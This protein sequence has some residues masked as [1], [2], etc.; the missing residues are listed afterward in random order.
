MLL[1]IFL[2][3]YISKSMAFF[4]SDTKIIFKNHND[5]SKLGLLSSRHI[6]SPKLRMSFIET[7]VNCLNVYKK[8]NWY[9]WSSLALS[10][11]SKI[12]I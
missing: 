6:K 3:V 8:N 2:M 11:T 7:A 1:Y 5:L 12:S 4:H 9:V 10:S